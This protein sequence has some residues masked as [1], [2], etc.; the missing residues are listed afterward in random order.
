MARLSY[1]INVGIQQAPVGVTRLGFGTPFIFA[2]V[3]PTLMPEF[4]RSYSGETILDDLVDEGFDTSHPVYLMA[5]ALTAHDLKPVR[6]IV[7]RRQSPPVQ[8]TN[9]SILTDDTTKTIKVTARYGG[10]TETYEVTGL[11]TGLTAMATALAA[12]INGG[13]FGV[14]NKVTATPD[15]PATGD[16]QVTQGSSPDAGQLFYYDDLDYIDIYDATPAPTSPQT[17]AADL[18]DVRTDE[19]T[20][21][22][23]WYWLVMDSSSEAENLAIADALESLKKIGSLQS[24]DS[25]ILAGTAGNL[26]DDLF[27]AKRAAVTAIWSRYGMDQYPGCRIVSY[28]APQD[29]GTYQIAWKDMPGLTADTRTKDAGLDQI[30]AYYGNIY[31]GVRNIT[32]PTWGGRTPDGKWAVSRQN[33]HWLEENIAANVADYFRANPT[34]PYHKVSGKVFYNGQWEDGSEAGEGIAQAVRKAYEELAGRANG[35]VLAEFSYSYP[36]AK[37]QTQVDIDNHIFRGFRFRGKLT[38]SVAETEIRG[39]LAT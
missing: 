23:D 14:A 16:V 26:F 33:V 17:I 6:I 15:T 31:V 7:G 11:G 37:Y 27:V 35:V 4:T 1:F 24:Q 5:S 32:N 30:R 29:V 28:A 20:G 10:E 18:S 25:L 38:G 3:D 39:F 8:V 21:S 2:Y 12:D 19:V 13:I 36:P 22:D 34:I 9:L